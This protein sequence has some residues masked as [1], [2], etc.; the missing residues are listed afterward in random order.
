MQIIPLP[1]KLIVMKLIY[2]LI[3]TKQGVDLLKAVSGYNS[4]VTM[5]DRVH[6]IRLMFILKSILRKI[7]LYETLQ[8][9]SET[10]LEICG[11]PNTDK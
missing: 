10:T 2:K 8:V 4:L 9:I 3:D 5:F 1:I 6:D 7:H 11:E